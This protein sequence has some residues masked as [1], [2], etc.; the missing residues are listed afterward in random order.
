M[1]SHALPTNTRHRRKYRVELAS[2]EHVKSIWLEPVS[3]Q[4]VNVRG[5]YVPWVSVRKVHVRGGGGGE[6]GCPRTSPYIA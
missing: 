3:V 2:S 6:G 4:G 5:I 1:M